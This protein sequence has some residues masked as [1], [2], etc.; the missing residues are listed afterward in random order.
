ML[1][2]HAEHG[3]GNNSTFACRV[4]TS[5]GTDPYAAYTTAINSLKGSRHGGANIKVVQML[6]C[7]KENVK[8]WGNRGEVAD[9]ITKILKKEAGD[10]SGLI[11]GMGHAVY[12]L[13]DPRAVILKR[14][15]FEMAKG[16]EI[17]AEFQLL[18]LIEELTPILMKEVRG[19]DKAMCANVDM[20]SGLVYRM[21]GIPDE[22]FTPLFAS[23]RMVGWAAH[24]MEELLTGKRIIRPAYKPITKVKPSVMRPKG[25]IRLLLTG[26]LLLLLSGCTFGA[27]V[28]ALLTPPHLRGEQEQ[29]Y[30]ALENAVGNR[31]T[32]QYPRSGDHLSAVMISDLD[33]DGQDEAAVFYRKE[34]SLSTENA[35]RLNLLDQADGT[36]M[37][38]CDLPAEGAEVDRGFTADIGGRQRLIIGYSQVDQS[39]KALVVYNYEGGTLAKSFT[40]SYSSFDV[41]DLDGDDQSELLI[42]KAAEGE[43]AAE[44]AVYVPDEQDHYTRYSLTLQGKT[45]EYSQ[46]L[47]GNTQGKQTAIY[48]DGIVGATTMQTEVLQFDG[49]KL[50]YLVPTGSDAVS[51]IRPTGWLTMDIDQDDIPEIPVQGLFPGYQDTDSDLIRMTRWMTVTKDGTLQEEERGYYSLGDGYA[52]LLPPNWQTEVTVQNDNLTGDLV[53]YHYMGDRAAEMPELMRIS[54]ATDTANRDSRLEEGYQLLYSRGNAYY[55]IKVPEDSTDERARTV[56][57]LLGYFV[58]LS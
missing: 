11:Y 31:I 40:V 21:L 20:Y 43:H 36:W 16:K 6:D 15:A 23:A 29:I 27:T 51:T 54:V 26:C 35:L 7:I 2:I 4:A 13:S 38:V 1:S 48:L 33:G 25:L 5:S 57:D 55:F 49:K 3:G 47:C 46:V 22:L 12:T 56:G 45:T 58:F 42:L 17:E 52:F 28:D 18:S 41:A 30:Q 8:N 53:F 34:S 9:F 24:R 32:L 19:V 14:K 50:S 10:G 44:A 39:D 37:S